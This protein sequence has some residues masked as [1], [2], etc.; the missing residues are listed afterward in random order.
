[1]NQP[2]EE[3]QHDNKDNGA[4]DEGEYTRKI[5]EDDCSELLAHATQ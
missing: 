1:M 2:P 5:S 4:D 3:S